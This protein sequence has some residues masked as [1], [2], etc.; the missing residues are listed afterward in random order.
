MDIVFDVLKWIVVILIAGFIGQ[1]G[2]SL[3]LQ[4][5]DYLKKKKE[6]EQGDGSLVSK[7]EETKPASLPQKESFTSEQESSTVAPAEHSQAEKDPALAPQ[8]RDHKTTKKTL[9]AQQ[10]AKKKR[11]K[12]LTKE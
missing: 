12:A 11:D 1:F 2:K 3:S 5:I 7:D 4:I 6:K 9:K 8:E 10:K